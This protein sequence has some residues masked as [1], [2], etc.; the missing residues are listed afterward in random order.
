M[1]LTQM[2]FDKK[3]RRV[4]EL[5]GDCEKMH[6]FVLSGFPDVEGSEARRSL[7]VLYRTDFTDRY[8]KLYVQSKIRPDYQHNTV[9]LE[10]EP[11]TICIDPLRDRIHNGMI[12]TVSVFANPI[13]RKKF[14]PEEK[15]NHKVFLKKEEERKVW[16]KRQ[17]ASGGAQLLGCREEAEEIV[18]GW[19]NGNHL[20]FPGIRW[21]CSIRIED[22][23]KFWNLFTDGVGSERAYGFGMIQ[24]WRM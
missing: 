23:E 24:I 10:D 3:N 12:L 11:K 1:Y 8:L 7:A 15:H 4:Y 19:R 22:E 20:Q 18:T 6:K 21:S 13:V 2:C 5:M 17:F 9:L 16:L 14:A